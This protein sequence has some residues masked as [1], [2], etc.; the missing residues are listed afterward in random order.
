MET[1][2]L[3]RSQAEKILG[4]VCAGLGKYFSMDPTVVRLIFV[5][6]TVFGASGILLYLILWVFIPPEPL[7]SGQSTSVNP[8]DQPA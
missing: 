4:G 1:K 3:Y 7:A 2:R 5:V 8:P 6:L